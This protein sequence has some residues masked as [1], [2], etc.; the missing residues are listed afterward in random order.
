MPKVSFFGPFADTDLSHKARLQP[1]AE[2]H[3]FSRERH[4]TSGIGWLGH[5]VKWAGVDSEP[6]EAREDALLR[7]R[8]FEAITDLPGEYE[9]TALVIAYEQRIKVT[10]LGRDVSTNNQF[11]I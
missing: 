3:C 2:L 7:S 8:I 11:L 6:L 9:L 10:L 4:A 1:T 5:I